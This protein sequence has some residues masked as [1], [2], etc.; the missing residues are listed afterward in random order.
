MLVFLPLST[1]LAVPP[2]WTSKG[3]HACRQK[4]SRPIK[5]NH[6]DRSVLQYLIPGALELPNKP[7]QRLCS[8]D[9]ICLNN[10]AQRPS[11]KS[12][13]IEREKMQWITQM[14]AEA[15]NFWTD[16]PRGLH[17]II[18]I[19]ILVQ[20]LFL[21]A[22]VMSLYV[23]LIVDTVTVKQKGTQT[24]DTQAKKKQSPNSNNTKSKCR[25]VRNTQVGRNSR[26]TEDTQ[27][28]LF[29]LELH[30]PAGKCRLT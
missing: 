13:V 29:T 27:Y 17:A 14:G 7:N 15:Q 1:G 28:C 5:T 20:N 2:S 25:N 8:S 18:L 19:L 11:Q 24:Q 26:N 22:P 16:S 10:C 6:C 4:K 12:D 9:H 21:S 3:L 30:L 23:F